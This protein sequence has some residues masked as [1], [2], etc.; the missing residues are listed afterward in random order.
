[1]SGLTTRRAAA[2]FGVARALFGVAYLAAPK[3]GARGW[4]GED[5]AR[6]GAT[7]MVFRSLGARDLVLGAG[8]ASAAILSED[9]SA[10]STW[11]LAHAVSD[12]AD[13]IASHGAAGSI[14]ESGRRAAIA[15]A[16][17]SAVV[18]MALSAALLR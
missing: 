12:T 6:R 13:A 2:A 18:S 14:P 4:L 3:R 7:Q 8:A 1:M 15:I 9:D 10:P 16:G 11:L 17:G 5:E